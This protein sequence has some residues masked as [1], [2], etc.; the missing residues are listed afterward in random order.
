MF[1]YGYNVYRLTRTCIML[2]LTALTAF[3]ASVELSMFFAL[4]LPTLQF[5]ALNQK[6]YSKKQII[7]ALSIAFFT[8]LAVSIIS[9]VFFNYLEGISFIQ[10][11]TAKGITLSNTVGTLV[12]LCLYFILSER[13]F[14]ENFKNKRNKKIIKSSILIIFLLLATF[15]SCIVLNVLFTLMLLSSLFDLKK[16]SSVKKEILFDERVQQLYSKSYE[17]R[18]IKLQHTPNIYLLLLESYHSK[19]ALQEIYGIDDTCTDDFLKHHGFTDYE[20]VYSNSH[21]TFTSIANIFHSKLHTDS[22]PTSPLILDILR[23]NGYNFEFFDSQFYVFGPYM[24]EKDYANFALS[25]FDRTVYLH[26]APL[27]GQT[28]YLRKFVRDIDPFKTEVNFLEI[29]NVFKERLDLERKSPTFYALRFG[30]NHVNVQAE[31]MKDSENFT[32]NTYPMLVKRAQFQIREIVNSITNKD[33][34]ALILALGDHGGLQHT[35]IAGKRNDLQSSFKACNVTNKDFALDMFGVRCAIRWTQPYK[36]KNIPLSPVNIFR[37]ILESLGGG[38]ALLNDLPQNLSIYNKTQ[39]IIVRDGKVLDKPEPF[40]SEEFFE[41]LRNMYQEGK[42]TVENCFLLA[43]SLNGQEAFEL[44]EW[45]H[46]KHP[47]SIEIKNAYITSLYDLGKLDEALLLAEKAMQNTEEISIINKYYSLMA[48]IHPEDFIA[49]SKAKKSKM[50][51]YNLHMYTINAL[52]DLG[53]REDVLKEIDNFMQAFPENQQALAFIAKAAILIHAPEKALSYFL[54]IK[55]Q[56]KVDHFWCYNTFLLISMGEWEDAEYSC[57]ILVEEHPTEAWSWLIYSYV[58][59]MQGK[60]KEA[61][62]VLRYG[63]QKTP[64]PQALKEAV[65]FM[66]KNYQLDANEFQAYK[67]LA[68][69]KIEEIF[70]FFTKNQTFDKEWYKSQ[71]PALK[72]ITFAHLHYISDGNFLGLNPTRWFNTYYYLLNNTEV[73]TKGLNPF[74]HFLEEGIN[75]LLSPSPKHNLRTLLA[76]D[77]TLIKDKER[78]I[79]EINKQWK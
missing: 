59:K 71:H 64:Y 56:R 7:I 68:E 63:E 50:T 46:K 15:Y 43:K 14:T 72:N 79:K 45:A 27:L 39:D 13:F 65:G 12:L 30:A 67:I 17:K 66:V 6:F 8:G 48:E 28:K 32:K 49:L 73:W 53:R 77:A 5:V 74:T 26:F 11:L 44:F 62:V 61:I 51:P 10:N 60:I 22:T 16:H 33:P 69:K 75:L 25:R 37:Y 76:K 29:Y 54:K 40:Y 34:D 20:N 78:F 58:L 70:K 21:N 36:T 18:K 3:M 42:L 19:A 55:F 1:F 9:V 4:F 41:N 52:I 24:Q 31:W 23:E 2:I 35:N 57:R 38:D 47:Q